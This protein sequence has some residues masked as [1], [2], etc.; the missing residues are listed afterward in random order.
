MLQGKTALVTGSSQGIGLGVAQAFA[1]SGA[2][3]VVTSEKP[4]A[5]CPDVQRLLSDYEHT[6]YI[7]ADLLADGEPERLVAEAWAAFGGLNVLVNN[8]GTYKEPPLARITR[9]HFDFV[10]RLNVWV[11][12]AVT[13][14]VVRRAQDAKRGGRIIFS[15][16]LNATRSEPLHTLYDASKGAVNAITRQ[17]A[18]E[19]APHGFTTA[20][21]APGLVETPLTDFGLKSS[22]AERAAV[23]SQ[24]PLRKIAT[25]DDVAWWYVFLASDRA[26][27]S[28]GSV[29][30]VDGGL[31]AQQMA[32]R[33]VTSVERA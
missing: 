18:V 13:R 20:A 32:L 17:L 10:F 26:S 27:Y 3:V 12:V 22:P 14:E 30:T 23:T 29:F 2:K 8:L 6:R 25:V 28:T 5:T 15:T 4:L 21:V 9:D 1:A 24:I 33:P 7:Q 31:D 16:S 19:L 11:P